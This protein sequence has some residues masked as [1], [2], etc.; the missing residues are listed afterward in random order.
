[1]QI[2]SKNMEAIGEGKYEGGN[3]T[4][5]LIGSMIKAN[6]LHGGCYPVG[7]WYT[8]LIKLKQSIGILGLMGWVFGFSMGLGNMEYGIWSVFELLCRVP[9]QQQFPAD[10]ATRPR[11]W[12]EV[13][14]M[15]V[16]DQQL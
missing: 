4:Y 1:M 14:T 2:W 5:Q 16:H 12:E 7:K 15:E 9:C 8:I 10:I 6:R 3:G 13:Q 11:P